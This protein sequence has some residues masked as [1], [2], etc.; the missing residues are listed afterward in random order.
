MMTSTGGANNHLRRLGW[1]A[2]YL[3]SCYASAADLDTVSR[4][5]PS[6]HAQTQYDLALRYDEGNGAA[7]NPVLAQRWYRRAARR[8]HVAAQNNLAVLYFESGKLR[9]AV[10]WYHV[11]AQNGHANAQFNLAVLY[12]LGRG[13]PQNPEKAV[14][15]YKSAAAQGHWNAQYNLARLFDDDLPP[16]PSPP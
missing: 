1:T 7:S 8:G 13:V 5:A 11:A 15:W 2:V 4:G 16:L 3:V 6:V 12:E 10:Y 9:K 14:Y